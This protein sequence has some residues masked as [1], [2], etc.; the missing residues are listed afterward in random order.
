MSDHGPG[1]SVPFFRDRH[2][3]QFSD[4][5]RLS[6]RQSV[7]FGSQRSFRGPSIADMNVQMSFSEQRSSGLS[8]MEFQN[9]KSFV[10][11]QSLKN[12]PPS[13]PS[14][15]SFDQ[16][17]TP[18]NRP[19]QIE[20]LFNP[21]PQ[22]KQNQPQKYTPQP[23]ELKLEKRIRKREKV[24]AGAC[25]CKA[26]KCLKLYCECFSKNVTCGPGCHCKNC[27]NTHDSSNIREQVLKQTVEKNPYA[28][29]AKYKPIEGQG[30]IL[31]SR[32]CNCSKTSCVKNYCECFNAGIGC[33]RICKCIN[34]QNQSI[35]ITE[36]QVRQYHEK[37][38]RKRRK[39]VIVDINS[40]PKTPPAKK[41]QK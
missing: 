40:L 5:F 37:V 30:T 27:H 8:S 17:R 21:T 35:S 13:R 28:F 33:S 14:H 39:K 29:R 10:S 19:S 7:D 12:I 15:V 4:V 11:R 23:K 31:H 2:S 38:L 20:T 36:E 9:G 6:L 41:I 26:S 34:C 16:T 1:E 3:G 22:V 24:T 18:L 25:R 32:G